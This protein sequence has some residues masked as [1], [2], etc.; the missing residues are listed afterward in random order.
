VDTPPPGFVSCL[1]RLRAHT[2]WMAVTANSIVDVFGYVRERELAS[3]ATVLLDSLLLQA[4]EQGFGDVIVP[5]VALAAHA[6]LAVIGATESP[7]RVASILRALI[8]VNDGAARPP[9][10]NSH[11]HRIHHELTV[12]RRTRGPTDDL[13]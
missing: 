6:R 5:A 10:T 2:A 13:A 3:V 8:G 11:Q 1:E 7:S 4:A 9:V 12:H